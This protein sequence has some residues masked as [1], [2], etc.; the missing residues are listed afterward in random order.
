MTYTDLSGATQQRSLYYRTQ[1]L[2]D[3]EDGDD[4]V[5]IHIHQ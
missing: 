5:G 2:Q 1:Y 3:V 4:F